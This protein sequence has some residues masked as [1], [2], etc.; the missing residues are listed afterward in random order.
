MV[1]LFHDVQSTTKAFCAE[2]LI[3]NID[4]RFDRPNF[5]SLYYKVQF[6]SIQTN[7]NNS[8]A[9]QYNLIFST[10]QICFERLIQFL[11]SIS[12]TSIHYF[13]P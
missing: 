10:K 11:R 3:L 8:T 2:N 6:F 7:N 4:L 9:R 12:I 5:H 13:Q 1:L